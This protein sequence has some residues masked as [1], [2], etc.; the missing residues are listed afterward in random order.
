MRADGGN[1]GTSGQPRDEPE[2]EPA[3]IVGTIIALKQR[4]PNQSLITL[5][6]DQV[7]Y[8]VRPDR[9]SLRVGDRVRLS[10]TGWGD[11]FRLTSDDLGRFIQVERVR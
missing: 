2:R 10:P 3:D 9:H 8:Q 11:S 7:W 1:G 5:G 6:N 4:E